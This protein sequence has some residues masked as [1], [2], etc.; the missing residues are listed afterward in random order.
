MSL[1]ENLTTLQNQIR[2][3]SKLTGNGREVKLIAVTKTRTFQ[4]IKDA[5]RCG[6]KSIGE[7]R[8]QEADSKFETFKEMPGLEKRF[9]GHLQSN[10]IKKCLLMF[11]T[12]DSIH[13]LRLA[14]KIN[15][16]LIQEKMEIK[17]LLEINMSGDEQKN[18]FSPDN[19]EEIISSLSLS[20]LKVEGLM[21]LGP[22]SR[23]KQ[24]TRKAFEGLRKLKDELNKEIGKESLT[25]LSMGMSGDFELGIEE[26]STMVRVGTALFGKRN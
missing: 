3:A 8:V 21:T 9:I 5:Y 12:I 26:G 1:K 25:E 22:A 6:I 16:H 4:I 18:G 24:E 11:D 23:D 2:A 14:R 7:N 17:A 13:S 20:C 19:K 15:N 10:K